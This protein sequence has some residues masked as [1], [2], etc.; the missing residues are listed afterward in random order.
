LYAGIEQIIFSHFETGFATAKQFGEAFDQTT[1]D[2]FESF[3]ESI[4]GFPVNLSNR[5]LKRIKRR[6]QILV[7]CIQVLFTFGLLLIFFDRG[8]INRSQSIDALV[9]P[10]QAFA[11]FLQFSFRIQVL[12]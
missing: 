1:V 12:L 10:L 5:T 7:L 8:Q 2:L 11:P 4:P 9:K 3:L 6:N